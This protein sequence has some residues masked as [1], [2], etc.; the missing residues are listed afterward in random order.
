MPQEAAGTL[1][2]ETEEVESWQ[3]M[4]S[5]PEEIARNVS[6]PGSPMG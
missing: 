3:R 2:V 1:M 5:G 6:N 4:K